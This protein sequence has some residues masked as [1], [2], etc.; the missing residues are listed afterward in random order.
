MGNGLTKIG[1]IGWILWLVAIIFIIIGV[2]IALSSGGFTLNAIAQ[3]SGTLF[4]IGLVGSILSSIGALLAGLGGFGLKSVVGHPLPMIA[5]I[6]GLIVG[7][8][9]FVALG[10]GFVDAGIAYWINLINGVILTGVFFVLLG[11]SL[12]IGP[13]KEKLAS[14]GLAVAAGIMNIIEGALFLSLIGNIIAPFFL[15]PVAILN[16]LIFWK[17]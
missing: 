10:L 15:I 7:I 1:A 11:V 3:G 2:I 13:V 6:F 8:L 9:G 17:A 4:I 5:G 16:V 12:I 14:P